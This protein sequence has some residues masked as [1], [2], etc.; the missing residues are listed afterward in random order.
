MRMQA[1]VAW[2]AGAPL[3]IE[4]FDLDEPRDDEILRAACC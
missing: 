2:E 3:S 4:E 1:A